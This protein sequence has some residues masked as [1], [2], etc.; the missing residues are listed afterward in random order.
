MT[1]KSLEEQLR[2]MLEEGA[3][4]SARIEHLVGH[5]TPMEPK[6]FERALA[7]LRREEAEHQ[8]QLEQL[9]AALQGLEDEP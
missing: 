1:E 2:D 6:L 4:I 3:G 5:A 7:Q 9:M 8:Q